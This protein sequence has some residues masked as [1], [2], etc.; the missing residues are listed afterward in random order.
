MSLLRRKGELIRSRM[1]LF[2]AWV[3]VL[4][5]LG[6][7]VQ[8]AAH[9]AA[10]PQANTH[11]MSD[12]F[13]T[14]QGTQDRAGSQDKAPHHGGPCKNMTLGCLVAMNCLSP[15]ALADSGSEMVAPVVVGTPYLAA[16][17]SRLGSHP[18]PPESPPPQVRLAV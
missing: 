5:G 17:A 9:A 1:R 16:I 18:A 8:V 12:C 7:F 15:L 14:A 2:H 3:L 11:D 10:L 13:V 4:L 6:L